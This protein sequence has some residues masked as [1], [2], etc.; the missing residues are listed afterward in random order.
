MA[1]KAVTLFD[2][3]H[4]LELSWT[5]GLTQ[6]VD[7]IGPIADGFRFV[8]L[9]SATNDET[10]ADLATELVAMRHAIQAFKDTIAP[11]ADGANAQDPLIIIHTIVLLASI[12]LDVAP[13][14]TKNSVE[15]ALEAVALVDYA[16][17]EYI[18]HVHPILGFLWTAIGQVL[19]DELIRIRG[20]ASKSREDTEQE[21]GMKN[22][23]DR[24][25][26]ALRACGVDCPYICE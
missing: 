7:V 19:I 26:V 8:P 23:A 14:W 1:C 24:L 17:F 22:A 18:G 2:R 25:I 15:N 4:S 21:A 16:S 10:R 6:R 9:T 20:L 12:R 3:A 11:L 5:A 13:S